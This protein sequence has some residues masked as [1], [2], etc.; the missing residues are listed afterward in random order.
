MNNYEGPGLVRLLAAV[1]QH[2]SAD[3]ATI[4]VEGCRTSTRS[5][6]GKTHRRLPPTPTALN[7]SAQGC[8]PRATLGPHPQP[9]SNPVRVASRLP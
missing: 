4:L 2:K 6:S 3:R 9:S 8:A 7:H 5:D 1:L